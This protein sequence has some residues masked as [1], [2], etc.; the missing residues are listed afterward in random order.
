MEKR[1][2]R[3]FIIHFQPLERYPPIMNLLDYLSTNAVEDIV[4]ISTH[5]ET[6]SVFQE[7][8]S[9]SENVEV[10]RTPVIVADSIFRIFSYLFFNVSTF[11]LLLKYKPKSVLYFE[12]ISSWPAIMYKKLKGHKVKLLV[13]YHEYMSPVEYRQNMRLVTKMYKLE[14]KMFPDNY[15]WISHTNQNRL[16]NFINDH[17]LEKS[18]QF[19]FHTMPNYPSKYWAKEKTSFNSSRKVRLVYVGS[20]GLQTMYLK[21][22]VTWV[23]SNKQSLSLNF[24]SH[25]IEEEAKMFLKSINDDCIIFHNACNYEELPGILKN[26]DVGLVIYKPVSENWIQNAPNKVFEYLACG[27]DVW[28]SKTITYALSIARENVYP[29]IIPLD[30]DNLKEFN[31]QKAIARNGINLKS[32]HFFYENVYGEIYKNLSER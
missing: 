23:L 6:G 20:L 19:I 11:Y 10:K 12:T 26:F 2:D 13:H 28:F 29:K 21:E 5:N 1:K 15:S 18:N 17:H 7:Y 3:I 32:N 16:N 14:G 25:N 24:Y 8:K 22:L 31:I 4:V 30:F 9:R 27:L